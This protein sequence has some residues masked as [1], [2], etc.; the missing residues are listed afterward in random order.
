[1]PDQHHLAAI[2]AAEPADDRLIVGKG[3]VSG[4]RQEIVDQA[5]DII[6]EVGPVGVPRDLRLLPRREPRIGVAKQFVGL[7]LEPRNLGI[8]VDLA[9][10]RRAAELG[11]PGLELGERLFEIKVVAHSAR[12]VGRCAGQNQRYRVASGWRALTSSTSRALSTWV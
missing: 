3:A 4:E 1:M 7:G 10:A 12:G 11:D 9:L 6:L 2:D 5:L 8:E